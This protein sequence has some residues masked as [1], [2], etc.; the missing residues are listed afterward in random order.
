MA[1][2]AVDARWGESAIGKGQEIL[3]RVAYIRCRGG[4]GGWFE[5][6]YMYIP[7]KEMVE[8]QG[9]PRKLK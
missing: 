7:Q 4:S 9:E 1:A 8:Q 2:S 6:I 3:Q 5:V